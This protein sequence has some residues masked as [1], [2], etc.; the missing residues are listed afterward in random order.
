MH[1][2]ILIIQL[3]LSKDKEF[4]FF[5]FKKVNKNNYMS[6]IRKKWNIEQIKNAF[7]DLVFFKTCTF[8]SNIR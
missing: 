5:P 4:L 3:N 2:L 8:V 6:K 7:W 1:I